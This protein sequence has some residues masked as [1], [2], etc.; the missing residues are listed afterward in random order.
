VSDSQRYDDLIQLLS[1]YGYAVTLDEPGY[2]VTSRADPNDASHAQNLDDL[3]DFADLLRWRKLYDV[4]RQARGEAVI[5][6]IPEMA[7]G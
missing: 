2:A 6:P 3:A 7:L 1:T 5:F 4:R